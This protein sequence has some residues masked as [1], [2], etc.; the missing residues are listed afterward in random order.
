M[1]I[2]RVALPVKV[3]LRKGHEPGNIGLLPDISRDIE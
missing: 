2:G 3:L 1:I